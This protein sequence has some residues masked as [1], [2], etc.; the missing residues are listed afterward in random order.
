MPGLFTRLAACAAIVAIVLLCQPRRDAPAV[1]V[2]AGVNLRE[3][4]D[5]RAAKVAVLPV[6]TEVE[7]GTC[8]ADRS[9]CRVQANGK[10]GWASASYLSAST[11]TGRV[12]L[13]ESEEHLRV[14]VEPGSSL[15]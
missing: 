2:S 8:L 3:A 9:W 1:T 11:A 7:L 12:R 14:A 5:V 10:A 6:G 13:A 15:E 4:P